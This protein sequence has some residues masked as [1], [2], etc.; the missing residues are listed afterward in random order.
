MATTESQDCKDAEAPQFQEG[1]GWV[2]WLEGCEEVAV[3][4]LLQRHIDQ[5][6]RF[7]NEHG[8]RPSKRCR[9]ISPNEPI[10][11]SISNGGG[12]LS[13]CEVTSNP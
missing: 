9:C 6:L 5:F 4:Q 11:G 13:Y 10:P 2:G 7:A 12:S 3:L 1:V 8:F